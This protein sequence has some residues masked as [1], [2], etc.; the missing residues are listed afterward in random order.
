MTPD[1]RKNQVRRLADELWNKGNGDYAHEVYAAHCSFHDP[2]FPVEGGPDGITAQA[3]EL[4]AAHPD[5]HI[6]VHEVLVDGDLSAA[7]WTM[8]GTSH[9]SFRGL[10]ATGKSW[11]MSGMMIDKWE[12]ER[13]VEEWVNYDTLGTLQ[14]TGIIPEMAQ[15]GGGA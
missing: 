11:V 2:S 9:G 6:D 13:I 10:P 8:G 12:D 7:R 14:Q 5:L 1:E 15:P 3:N 4:R